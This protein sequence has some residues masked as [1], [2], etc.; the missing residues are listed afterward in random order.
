MDC[1]NY[2][3]QENLQMLTLDRENMARG[4]HIFISEIQ[5]ENQNQSW[6]KNAIDTYIKF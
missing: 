5:K 4:P 2:L 6:R 3:F 1:Q